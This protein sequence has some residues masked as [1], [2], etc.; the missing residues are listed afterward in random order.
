MIILAF[1]IFAI[2]TRNR[3]CRPLKQLYV[4][5]VL[6]AY[7]VEREY[8]RCFQ[9]IYPR[10][11]SNCVAAVITAM[12]RPQSVLPSARDASAALFAMKKITQD[13]RYKQTVIEYSMKHNVA[14]AAIRYK[15]SRQNIYRWKK[16]YDVDIHSLTDRSHRPH[17][18][19]K[20]HTEA[21]SR[22]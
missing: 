10:L 22:W 3:Q 5:L 4:A 21:E 20:Q 11:S 19:P 7:L 14:N 18:H 12:M 6:K 13:M 8:K 17:S 2:K 15:T 1:V 9:K 16:K